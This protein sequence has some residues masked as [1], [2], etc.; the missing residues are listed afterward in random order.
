MC[1]IAGKIDW[2]VSP[3]VRAVAKMCDRMRY[4]GPDNCGILSLD[5]ITLGHQRLSI[6]DL[7]EN[8][9]QPMASCDKRYYIVYN[10]EVYNFKELRKEL[11]QLGVVF[12]TLSDTEVVL[13]SYIQWGARCLDRFNGMFALAIWDN[14]LKELFLARD[15]FGKKPLYYYK[16]V[17]RMAFSS[18]LT[19]LMCDTDIPRQIS[20]EALNSY[21]ALGYILSPM[22]LY[23]DIFKLESATFM[24]VSDLGKTVKKVRY[25]DY[26]QKFREKVDSDEDQIAENILNLLNEAVKKRMVSDVPIGA[27]LSGGIDSSSVS[28][29]MKKYHHGD[30]HTFSIGFDQDSYSEIKD[31]DRAVQ[32]IG[33]IHHNRICNAENHM[34]LINDALAAYDEPFAD[35][36]CVP[37][38]ALARL[39]SLHVKVALSGDGADEIF[40]GYITYKADRYYHYAKILPLF[41]R[42]LLAK[43]GGNMQL[44]KQSKLSFG[45]RQKQ[46]FHGTLHSPEQAHYLWRIMFHPEERVAIL[47]E[48]KRELIYDTDPFN[49]FK[50]YYE[51]ADGLHWLDKNLY[52]D[53]MTWLT[54]DIL[55]KIDRASMK[56]SIEVRSPYLDVDLASYT[57]SIPANLKMKGLKTKYILKASLKNTLP[58]FILNKRKSG[59]NAPVG[60]WLGLNT[61][62]EFKSFNKY[63]FDKKVK[64][65]LTSNLMDGKSSSKT[66]GI[67]K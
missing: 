37:T 16:D 44:R 1:G 64:T 56:N 62:D 55:V 47:G 61:R 7:S 4:R 3:G 32:W 8:A 65:W 28:S 24:I 26:V 29:L 40:A 17:S 31:A 19:A 39:A 11:Q 35:N 25:W 34:E 10:G 18:E 27:F 21:L 5:N 6:I 46:F 41:M 63:V 23:K 52:V 67:S 45:Y 48:D 38:F 36:S 58:S 57:A 15:K 42:K 2:N 51:K 66:G 50:K 20:Y 13:Y 59:F 30:L 53:A 33:T 22:T 12:K 49:V 9:N 14:N 54:D 43:F 60:T